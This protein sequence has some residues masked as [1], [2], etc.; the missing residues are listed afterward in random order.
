MNTDSALL[1][2]HVCPRPSCVCVRVRACVCARA[3]EIWHCSFLGESSTCAHA[4][5]TGRNGAVGGRIMSVGCF[6]RRR[7]KK[8][9][10][11]EGGSVL[12]SFV[13]W[14]D[15]GDGLKEGW[16]EGIRGRCE[17]VGGRRIS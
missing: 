12:K 1:R 14:K 7:G 9:K 5:R 8:R 15:V 10:A 13:V 2:A 6:K 3:G 11:A 16:M 17:R 4:K